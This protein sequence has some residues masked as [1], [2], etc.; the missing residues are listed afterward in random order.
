[1]VVKQ[2]CDVYSFGVIV[3]ENLVGRHPRDILSL[4]QSASTQNIKLCEILDQR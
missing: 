4:F 1:M 2:K 3:L